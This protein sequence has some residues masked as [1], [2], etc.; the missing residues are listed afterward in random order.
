MKSLVK[1]LLLSVTLLLGAGSQAAVFEFVTTL[2]G[3]AE[4]PP[5]STT[6]SGIAKIFFDDVAQTLDVF[7]AFSGLTSPTSDAHIHCCTLPTGNASVAVGFSADFPLGVTSGTYE[8]EFDLTDTTIYTAGFLAAGGGTAAGASAHLLTNLLAGM[9]YV[10][11][12]T[13]ANPKGEIRGQ[14]QIP[15]P[16][17][18]LLLSVA[19]LVA[20][21][22]RRR[23]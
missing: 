1:S 5:V 6:G 13:N 18:L 8:R 9:A 10:N 12:H 11:I 19:A 23:R 22:I 14:L 15:E 21:G 3:G 2:S 4:N 7:V 20:A 17:T 16:G